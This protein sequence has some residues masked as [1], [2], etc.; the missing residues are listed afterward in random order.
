[1][2]QA[3]DDGGRRGRSPRLNRTGRS[4]GIHPL[5]T[6]THDVAATGRVGPRR[7]RPSG[8]RATE[9][10]VVV[11]SHP[12]R[13]RLARRPRPGG[14]GTPRL[15]G[16]PTARRGRIGRRPGCPPRARVAAPVP[17]TSTCPPSSSA[18]SACSSWSGRTTTTPEAATPSGGTAVRRPAAS[19]TMGSQRADAGGGDERAGRRPARRRDAALHRRRPA[20]ATPTRLR[21]RGGASLERRS[22]AAPAGR[23]CARP[24]PTSLRTSWRPSATS[25]GRPGSLRRPVRARPA[26]SPSACAIWSATAASIR[27]P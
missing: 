16:Q 27:A 23:P 5:V 1:M 21:G 14:G 22:R 11:P 24:S 7:R 2:V 6:M 12:H 17:S 9:S 18:A 10:L 25:P 26:C 4:G 15:L 19:P 3:T 20:P 8:Y 13:R